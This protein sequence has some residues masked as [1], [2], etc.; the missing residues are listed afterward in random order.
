MLRLPGF[1]L[2]GLGLSPL[3]NLMIDLPV[4][5]DLQLYKLGQGV[6]DRKADAMKSSGDLV[7]PII[8]FPS[9]M[10]LHHDHF[11]GGPF[12]FLVEIDGD[13]P[14]IISHRDTVIEMNDDIDAMTVSGQ[15]FIDA[16]VN[17]FMD[18]MME[19]FD[20]GISDI[21][22]RPLSYRGQPLQDLDMFRRI[23]VGTLVLRFDRFLHPLS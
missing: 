15:G 3:L 5:P 12:L 9:R 23:L 13:P 14:A 22:G 18:E 21:H 11:H 7:R 4:P 19:P 17:Q 10:E 6:D 1:L 8:E 2:L 16:V 20:S